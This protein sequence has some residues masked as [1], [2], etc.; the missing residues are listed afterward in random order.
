MCLGPCTGMDG[1][2]GS[3]CDLI[4]GWTPV[5]RG[6]LGGKGESLVAEARSRGKK[7]SG[8]SRLC[9][10]N[11][12]QISVTSN[13]DG[14]LSLTLMAVAGH[15]GT[16]CLLNHVIQMNRADATSQLAGCRGRGTESSRPE[17]SCMALLVVALASV[18]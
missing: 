9:C 16:L 10:S 5:G 6:R 2:T 17:L 12:P 8:S 11:S 14:H 4:T 3:C 15:L 1:G 18:L 7:Q 13:N